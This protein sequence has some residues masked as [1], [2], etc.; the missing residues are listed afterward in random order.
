MEE[1]L[2]NKLEAFQNFPVLIKI[3]GKAALSF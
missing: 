3:M 2:L 1:P